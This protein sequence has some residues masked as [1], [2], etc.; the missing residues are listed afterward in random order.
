[1]ARF[2][3][4]M[5]ITLL[6]LLSHSPLLDARNILKI[7]T[8]QLLSFKATPPSTHQATAYVVKTPTTK[9]VHHFSNQEIV[10]NPSPGEGH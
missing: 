8:P 6:L 4:L 7:H 10:S 9:V 5:L 3:P 2:N 1:M